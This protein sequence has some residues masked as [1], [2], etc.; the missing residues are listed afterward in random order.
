M[1]KEFHVFRVLFCCILCAVQWANAEES[2][3]QADL[4]PSGNLVEAVIPVM[5]LDAMFEKIRQT[6]PEVLIERERVRR[7]LQE[8]IEERAALL[9][10]VSLSASQLRRQ[11]GRRA[12]QGPKRC[13]LIP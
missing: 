8:K 13:R 1:Y 9:P 11:L 3:A 12:R 4:K 7:A 10:Q 5:T 6:S 2:E